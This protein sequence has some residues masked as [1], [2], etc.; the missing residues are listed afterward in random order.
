MQ[1]VQRGANSRPKSAG[2]APAQRRCVEPR[3]SGTRPKPAC[4][5]AASQTL[6]ITSPAAQHPTL[7]TVPRADEPKRSL[8]SPQDS[9]PLS[10]SA[11]DH[12]KGI[13]AEAAAG[14]SSITR[15]YTFLCAFVRYSSR[16]PG[17]RRSSAAVEGRGWE[18]QRSAMNTDW[19]EAASTC[20]QVDRQRRT[21][22]D[23]CCDTGDLNVVHLQKVLFD[24]IFGPLR[25]RLEHVMIVGQL[26]RRSTV[27]GQ[28]HLRKV[29]D[30]WLQRHVAI[31]SSLALADWQGK[32]GGQL[33]RRTS[34]AREDRFVTGRLKV[35]DDSN[36]RPARLHVMAAALSQKLS[37]W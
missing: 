13:E 30:R 3:E 7:E 37:Q 9:S 35:N 33:L 6:Q 8:R 17:T 15:T 36:T 25:R 32:D 24:L 10:A 5:S 20:L 34:G 16:R 26:R 31:L 1:R 11:A 21:T 29:N 27:E 2:C 19:R 14:F 12:R 23:R 22:R 28:S 18:H 4:A